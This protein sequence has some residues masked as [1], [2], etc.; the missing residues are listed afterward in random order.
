MD[1]RIVKLGAEHRLDGFASRRP[2]LD[3]W[4]KRHALQAQRVD[5]S[6]TYVS[7]SPPGDVVAGYVS[8]ATGSIVPDDMNERIRKGMARGLP[9]P[10]LLLARLAVGAAFERQGVGGSLLLHAMRVA[11]AVAD[12]VGVRSLV[13]NPIDDEAA[14]FYANYDFERLDGI[15]PPMMCLLAKDIRKLVAA[16]DARLALLRTPDA[17]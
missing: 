14:A 5:A 2:T 7:L 9:I 6:V 4:L 17:G 8:L 10:T 11:V 13:V 1:L 16:Y 15:S 12:R 3:D